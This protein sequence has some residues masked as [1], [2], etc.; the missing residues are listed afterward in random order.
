MLLISIS[1]TVGLAVLV[2]G[3]Y[4]FGRWVKREWFMGTIGEM[5]DERPEVVRRALWYEAE[6]VF[7]HPGGSYRRATPRQFRSICFEKLVSPD[8]LLVIVWYQLTKELIHVWHQ[9]AGEA[10][11]YWRI[12]HRPN[13][14]DLAEVRLE[15]YQGQSI[16]V[17][18][19][20]GK[21]Q[22]LLQFVVQYRSVSDFLSKN[23]EGEEWISRA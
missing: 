23:P 17:T 16:V 2:A 7:L 20:Q 4:L 15:D 6:V 21:P 10:R 11:K 1:I 22:R 8:A 3:L 13:D 9:L 18:L 12:I 14:V 19:E 5:T